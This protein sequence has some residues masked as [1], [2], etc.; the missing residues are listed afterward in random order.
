MCTSVCRSHDIRKPVYRALAYDRD[1]GDNGHVIYSLPDTD[2][3]SWWRIDSLTGE[4][5][6]LSD[7]PQHSDI[8]VRVSR[9]VVLL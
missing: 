2:D 6:L 1:V 3:S 9:A 5:Y 4:L 7:W 8:I